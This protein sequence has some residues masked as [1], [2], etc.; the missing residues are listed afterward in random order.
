MALWTTR[1][2]AGIAQMVERQFCKL[3]VSGS[4]PLF[5]S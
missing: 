5:G 1:Q 4:I 3:N 2:N